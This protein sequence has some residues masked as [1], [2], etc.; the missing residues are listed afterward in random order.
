MSGEAPT[1]PAVEG[2][3]TPLEEVRAQAHEEPGLQERL[4]ALEAREQQLEADLKAAETRERELLDRLARLGADFE[5]FRRRSREDS[6]QASAR[7]KSDFVKGLLPVLDN[8]DRALAH[9]QDEGLRLL[10]RHLVDTLASQG[11][12][13]VDPV[14]VKFDANVHEALAQESRE[15]AASGTILT[16]VEKGY[17]LDGRILRPA[18]VVVAA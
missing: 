12:L 14:G 5:N 7:G 16:V 1:H 2:P 8:L 11:L 9:T 18:R 4:T 17:A 10:S 15:G 3:E 6:A 13:V